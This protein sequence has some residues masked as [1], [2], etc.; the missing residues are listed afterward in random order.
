MAPQAARSWV[1]CR[2]LALAGSLLF[3]PLRSQPPA[4]DSP[5]IERRVDGL[6]AQLT[7]GQKIDLLGGIDSMY[8]RAAPGFPQLKMSDGPVGVRSWG[9]T[10]AY[11]AG[12]ALAATWDPELARRLG[13]A[14]GDDA[15]ARGVHFLLGP[16]VNIARAPLNGRN[17]EYFGEDPFLAARMTVNVIQGVQSRGVVATVKHFAL[18]NS[19]FDRLN[20]SADVDER[21]LREIYLPAFEAAVKEAHVGAVMNSYNL[22]NGLHATESPLLNRE[23]LKGNWAFDGLLMSDWDAV[24]ST[25]PAA[26]AGTD[27]EMP[28]P[29]FFNRAALLPAIKAGTVTVATIDDKLRRLFRT[30]L[31]FGFLDRPQADPGRP[32]YSQEGRQV[33]LDE[34]RGS[35]VLLRNQGGLL[36]LD[37]AKVRTIAV[38]G[39]DAWPAVTGGGGSSEATPYRATSLLT[40]VGDFAGSRVRVLYASGLPTPG[41]LFAETVF[42]RDGPAPGLKMEVFDTPDFSGPANTSRIEHAVDWRAEMWTPKA[43]HPRSVRWSARCYSGEVGPLS[44]SRGRGRRG[45]VLALRGR[46]AAHPP[47]LPGGAGARLRGG[48]A[49]GREDHCRAPGLPALLRPSPGW[50]RDP[51]HGRPGLA[52]GPDHRRPGRRRA[53]LRGL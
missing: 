30:A 24:N 37:R 20:L 36:P 19:E 52:G 45:P 28:K 46:E 29:T 43:V 11:T 23:I 26:N 39:P 41:E 27:L 12:V 17:F 22:V 4:P 25:V 42:D 1:P 53:R 3:V 21:T 33:A 34:A 47:A 50:L 31:R 9:P 14:L 8:T 16:G 15:R 5:A 7:L 18:N 44:F 2:W 51:G 40:G 13:E 49:H 10:T 32:L 48:R 6:L 35:M 38:I